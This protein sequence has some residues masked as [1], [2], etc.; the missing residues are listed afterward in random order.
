MASKFASKKNSKLKIPTNIFELG[1]YENNFS[2][3]K[4]FVKTQSL[5]PN[6]GVGLKIQNKNDPSIQYEILES[7]YKGYFNAKFYGNKIVNNERIN[8]VQEIKDLNQYKVV[9]KNTDCFVNGSFFNIEK[10]N[11]LIKT[12]KLLLEE[13]KK[14]INE[15]IKDSKN[16]EKK[17]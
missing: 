11:S 5:F 1:V 9:D 13:R 14:F 3:V 8:T 10:M 17:K 16:V 4:S 12:K 15:Q 2:K 7:D 6:L